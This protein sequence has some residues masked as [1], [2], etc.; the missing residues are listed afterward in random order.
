MPVIPELCDT[1][2]IHKEENSTGETYTKH[3]KITLTNLTTEFMALKTFRI[4][5]MH[6]VNK[7]IN[8]IKSN[9]NNE[10]TLDEVKHLRDDNNSKNTII[11]LLAENISDITK[12]FS[13]KLIQEQPFTSPKKHAKNIKSAARDKNIALLVN[14]F[15]NLMFDYTDELETGT[16]KKFETHPFVIF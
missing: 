16:N 1:P 4:D 5:E 2:Q 12:S 8:L 3:N 14:R 6:Y 7:N 11:K 15:S 10:Q 13:S 9:M